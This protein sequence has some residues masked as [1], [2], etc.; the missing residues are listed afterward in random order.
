MTDETKQATEEP[1]SS[2]ETN[3][4]PWENVVRDFQSLGRNI[5]SAVQS[6]IEEERTK[7]RLKDLQTNI[8]TMSNQV[9]KAI[10]EAAKSPK[11]SSLKSEAQKAVDEARVFGTKAYG[12]AKPHL[13]T[14]MESQNQGIQKIIERL[15][16]VEAESPPPSE[17]TDQQA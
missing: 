4:N 15:H 7:E 11:V 17:E 1:Q 2:Q 12:E 13:N 10:D 6:T 16:E 8:E 9:T 3:D 14:A 5:A